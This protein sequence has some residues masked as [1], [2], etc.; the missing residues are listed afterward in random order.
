MMNPRFRR[1]LD[2]ATE[3]AFATT[4]ATSIWVG[5]DD[6]DADGVFQDRYRGSSFLYK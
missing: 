6:A 3:V 1:G 4:G 5:C 2:F